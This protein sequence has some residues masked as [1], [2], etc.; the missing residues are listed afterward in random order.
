MPAPAVSWTGCYVSAG[1]GYG[2]LDDERTTNDTAVPSSTSAAKGWMGT[3][4]GGC[5]YQF[6]GGSPLGPIVVGVFGDY[7]PMN[8]TGNY[9]DPFNITHHGT[10][11]ERD[12]WYFGGRAGIL[13]TPTLLTYID[14]G[15]TGTHVDRINIVTAGGAPVLGGLYLPSENLSGWFIGSGTEYAFTWLP[16]HGLFWKTEYRYSSYDN[17]DQN[18]I[19]ASGL[20]GGNLI[21]NSVDVQTITSSLVWRF[22]W[23]GR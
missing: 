13:V 23:N 7:D 16:I 11:N 1:F 18:Y 19:H 22:N 9:G 6:G 8:I 12:A 2:M 17:Y 4:G 10:Q 14:G 15:W 5:D 20:P 21:H 3:F